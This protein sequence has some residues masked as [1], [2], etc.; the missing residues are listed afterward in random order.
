MRNDCSSIK[1]LSET[2]ECKFSDQSEYPLF[3]QSM[4]VCTIFVNYF[5]FSFLISFTINEQGKMKLP[6]SPEE[7]E[8]EEEEKK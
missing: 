4:I 7:E 2:V 1:N 8:E 6:E 3:L 5:Y